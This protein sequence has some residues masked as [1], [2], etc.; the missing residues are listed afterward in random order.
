MGEFIAVVVFGSLLSVFGFVVGTLLGYFA[1]LHFSYPTD[2]LRHEAMSTGCCA[3]GPAGA[4]T[5]LAAA[6][7]LAR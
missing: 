3:A 4:M 7:W 6:W 2:D 1:V 5:A